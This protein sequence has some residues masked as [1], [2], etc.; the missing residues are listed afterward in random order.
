MAFRRDGPT[1]AALRAIRAWV[2]LD[3]AFAGFNRHLRA[4]TGLT[5]AQLAMLRVV[6]ELAPVGLAELRGRLVMH[7]ATLGQLLDRLAAKG[8]VELAS[9]PA[10]GRRRVVSVTGAGGRL[11]AA[12]PLAGP[13]RLR[14]VPADERRLAA[15]A[16][17]FDD[18]VDLFGLGAWA[19]P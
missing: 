3:Q 4:T 17:A 2:R 18:A 8:L 10:D 12:A 1:E 16:D 11:V 14:A 19:R 15:L 6:V 7:P 9:D 13:V 5:G